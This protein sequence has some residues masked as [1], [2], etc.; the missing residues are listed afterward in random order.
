MSKPPEESSEIC[1]QVSH[2]L[3]EPIATRARSSAYIVLGTDLSQA[4]KVVGL[5]QSNGNRLVMQ[6]DS[7]VS[8]KI[9]VGMESSFLAAIEI[10]LQ[11]DMIL[12]F[13]PSDTQVLIHEPHPGITARLLIRAGE[14]KFRFWFSTSKGERLGDLWLQIHPRS[15]NM[16]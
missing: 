11:V 1:I 2:S 15:P 6:K 5:S 9:P 14:K 16:L 8:S 12:S 3:L 4:R 10:E 13:C 7:I